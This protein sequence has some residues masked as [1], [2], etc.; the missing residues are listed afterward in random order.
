MPKKKKHIRLPNGYGQIRYLGKGRTLPYA[1]HPPATDRNERGE[2]IRPKALCYVPDWY[3]GFAVLSAYHA[4]NYKPGLE[5]DLTY[6]RSDVDAFIRKVM[7]HGVYQGQTGTTFE[8]AYKSFID[9][10]FGAHAARQL[11]KA[12]R[13]AYEQG[14]KYLQEIGQRQIDTISVDDLQ[15][16]VNS[17]NKKQ[18]TRENIVMTAKSIYKYAMQREMCSKDPAKYLIVPAGGEDEHGVPFTD[19]ELEKLWQHK[20]DPS[21]QL[22]L[23]MCYSGFRIGALSTLEVNTDRWFFRGGIKTKSSKGRIVPIHSSIREIAA[24]VSDSLPSLPTTPKIREKMIALMTSLGMDHTPHDCRHTFSMLCERYGVNEAD[25]KR[26]MG[27]SF[28][29]D[30][31]NAVYGHRALEDLRVEIE[32]IKAPVC[33]ELWALKAI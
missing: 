5:L 1:V 3:T 12:T 16:I 10:K 8:Q 17:C 2:Y 19:Q 11:S 23:L 6:D 7:A 27:H 29:N 30:I 32:K 21:A 26:M 22:L 18:A 9:F 4:G 14:W 33:G 24:S 25:R 20:D 13:Y 31:T 15:R 28:G